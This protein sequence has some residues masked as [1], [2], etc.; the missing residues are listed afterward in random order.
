M[1]MDVK[2]WVVYLNG[3][4]EYVQAWNV[5]K[6]IKNAISQ[7]LSQRPET[8]GVIEVEGVSLL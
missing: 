6:A 3:T 8:G 7:Y 2:S 1:V 4:Y 5:E